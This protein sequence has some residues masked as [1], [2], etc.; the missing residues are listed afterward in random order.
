M[1]THPTKSIPRRPVSPARLPRAL[2]RFALELLLVALA[3][4]V[5]G[6][7]RALTEGSAEQAVANGES[8]LRVE[9]RLGIAQEATVQS[10]VLASDPLVALANW[11]YIWGHW[12]VIIAAAVILY[13]Q[14][15]AS[16]FLLRN[17]IF[18]SGAMGFL[19]FALFP[20]RPRG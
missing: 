5:Y 6:G 19:F 8:L 2:P 1:S 12:P 18:V 3:A 11:V 9:Q 7:V 10:A 4:G 15:R 16:Y 13:R 17:A 20:S 14:R